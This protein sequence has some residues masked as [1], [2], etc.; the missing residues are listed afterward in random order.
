MRRG[1]VSAGFLVGTLCV[2]FLC[3]VTASFA[4]EKVAK[5]KTAVEKVQKAPTA[6]KTVKPKEMMMKPVTAPCPDPAA[7]TLDFEIVS[8]T[9]DF[10]GRVRIVGVVKNLGRAAYESGPNQQ[11][12]QL[13]EDVQG[14]SERQP[15]ASQAF[16]DLAPNQ[17]VRVS[18]ERDWNAS[19]PAEGE[20]PPSYI[21][22]ISYDPD[23]QMDGNEA[24]DDC[25][26][27]NNR[28]ERSGM[29]INAMFGP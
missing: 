15:V 19:S 18:Y 23:I 24:N 29:D 13:W 10:R 20:F 21:L 3:G 12:V 22:M 26:A 27:G 7:K 14:A 16:Q 6:A 28:K 11:S 5:P 25:R 17:E 2:V 4:A 1:R 8:R 9:G